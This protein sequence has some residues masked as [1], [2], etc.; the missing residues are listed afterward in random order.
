ML[1]SVQIHSPATLRKHAA[2]A[3]KNARVVTEVRP[4]HF[5]VCCLE[6]STILDVG[7]ANHAVKV[8]VRAGRSYEWVAYEREHRVIPQPFLD[9]LVWRVVGYGFEAR[10]L[11]TSLTQTKCVHDG[12]TYEGV[13]G[14]R[15]VYMCSPCSS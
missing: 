10:G 1:Q 13:N 11:D 7:S 15:G 6:E 9:V 2:V 8:A 12:S 3:S 14:I 4:V 5:A